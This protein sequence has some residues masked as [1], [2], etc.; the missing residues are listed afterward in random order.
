[1]NQRSKE[2]LYLL[3][4]RSQSSLHEL[5]DIHEV[6]ERTIRNDI[7]SL[8]DYLHNLN[9]GNISIRQKQAFLDLEVDKQKLYDDLNRFN[10]YEYRFS[11][12]ERSL[13]CL[14]ILIGQKGYVTLNQL[15]EKLLA[16]RSTIVNDVKVMRKI[17]AENQLTVLSRAN[18]GYQVQAREED[19]RKFLYHII[20]QENFTI[21]ESIIFEEGYQTVIGTSD[22]QDS[23]EK[24]RETIG[25]SE[26]QLNR[27]LRYLIIS[28]YRNWKGFS[29]QEWQFRPTQTFYD[30]RGGIR[31]SIIP[32]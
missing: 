24:H 7:S 3:L 9:V 14:L 23:L 4:E 11:S 16:S 6:S 22:L 12:E 25:L 2:I 26:K 29:L 20:S 17:A 5:S 19:I 18:K 21:L 32:I 8:N 27:M 31:L 28:S 1:M 15:S 30:L 10:V 13:I